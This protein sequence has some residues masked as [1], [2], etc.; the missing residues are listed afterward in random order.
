MGQVAEVFC[1]YYCALEAGA[2]VKLTVNFENGSA[3]WVVPAVLKSC[4]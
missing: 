4:W 2:T 1:C 3:E